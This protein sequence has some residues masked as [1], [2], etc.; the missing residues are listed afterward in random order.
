MVQLGDIKITNEWD[1][2]QATATLAGCSSHAP[3]AGPAFGLIPSAQNMLDIHGRPTI[4]LATLYWTAEV[5]RR[6]SEAGCRVLLTGQYGNFTVSYTG[7]GSCVTPALHGDWKGMKRA[8]TL[9]EPNA[10]LLFKRHIAKPLVLTA[11]HALNYRLPR[12]ILEDQ[13]LMSP[14]FAEEMWPKIANSRFVR[15]RA[16]MYMGLPGTRQ[17]YFAPGMDVGGVHWYEMGAGHQLDIRDPTADRRLIELFYRL[18]DDLFWRKG[19]RRW[20]IKKMMQGKMPEAVLYAPRRGVQSA[21]LAYRLLQE[22]PCVIDLLDQWENKAEVQEILNVNK[23]REF[24]ASI[25]AT[26]GGQTPAY[27]EMVQ[28]V[29]A[30]GVG[31]FL[32]HQ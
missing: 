1:L 26:G 24:I 29:R 6:A 20:I 4:S 2:A 28:Y 17:D 10:W 23:M 27:L 19:N 32:N 25:Q 22:R 30:L 21:D 14:A 13:C 7:T 16:K 3:V 31:H 9:A 15:S 8:L 18:P 5:L 12:Q 11:R